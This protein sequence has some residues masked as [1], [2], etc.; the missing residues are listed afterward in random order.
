M[1]KPSL[2][3]AHLVCQSMVQFTIS[4]TAHDLNQLYTHTH[5]DVN[6]LLEKAME[7]R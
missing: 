2:R 5:K 3:Q 1:H 6:D 7:E 4:I